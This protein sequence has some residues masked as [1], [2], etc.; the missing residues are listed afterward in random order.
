M[1]NVFDQ[2]NDFAT[3]MMTEVKKAAEQGEVPAKKL[4]RHIRSTEADLK[5]LIDFSSV[6]GHYCKN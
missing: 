4:V 1:K 2:L 6:N 5:R 3:Q